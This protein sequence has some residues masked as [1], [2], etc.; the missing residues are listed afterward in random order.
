MGRVTAKKKTEKVYIYVPVKTDS[1]CRL[2]RIWGVAVVMMVV[3][4]G[5]KNKE[6]ERK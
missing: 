1:R 6:E 5:L 3:V 4:G 2:D